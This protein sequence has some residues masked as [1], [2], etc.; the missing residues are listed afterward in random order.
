[1]I[2][3]LWVEPGEDGACVGMRLKAEESGTGRPDEVIAA[4]GW[5]PAA[6]KIHRRRIIFA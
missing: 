3:D 1:L 2:L 6:A 4:L 5:D